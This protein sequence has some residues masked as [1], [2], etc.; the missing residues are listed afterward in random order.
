MRRGTVDKLITGTVLALGMRVPKVVPTNV[1]SKSIWQ[2]KWVRNMTGITIKGGIMIGRVGAG[3]VI[4]EGAYDW[5]R[6]ARC[7]CICG[8]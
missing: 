7:A 6:I 5:Y 4:I 1:W 3:L 2:V 8:F